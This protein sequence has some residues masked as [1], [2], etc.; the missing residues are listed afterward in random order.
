V[1][2]SIVLA[3]GCGGS[4]SM[5]AT[6]EALCQGICGNEAKLACP[7]GDEAGCVTGCQA[8]L[9]QTKAGAPNCVDQINAMYAC[10]G[11]VAT[12]SI[13]CSANGLPNYDPGFCAAESAAL[14]SCLGECNT[15]GN[16]ATTIDETQVAEALPA[17]SA[18][19]GAFAPGTYFRTST[20][21]YT[22]VGGATGPNGQ[23]DKQ[24][25]VVSAASSGAGAIILQ[26]VYSGNG[27]PDEHVTLMGTPTGTTLSVVITCPESV[28]FGDSPY[29][30]T[31]TGFTLYD[32]T[33]I[34]VA[35]YAKQ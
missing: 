26:S 11:K 34:A 31:A 17:A 12:T 13:H 21:V 24:T 5:T 32:T 23:T 18:A 28:P 16:T 6:P 10:T 33:K 7:N 22:G 4:S 3:V 15:V 25:L 30:A 29:T 8:L 1:F 27:A 35:V 20:T 2:A 9:A 14:T 19:G